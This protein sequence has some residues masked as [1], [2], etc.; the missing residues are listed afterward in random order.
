ML[1]DS[2]ILP[3][4]EQYSINQNGNQLC[5]Y[6]GLDYSLRPQLQTPFSNPQ[7]NPQQ[8]AYNTVMSKARVGV[9]W[10]FGDIANFFKFLDFKKSF[11]LGLSPI[12]KMY[13][14]CGFLMNIHTC[15]CSSMTSSYFNIDPPTVH[16][17]LA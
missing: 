13:I 9:E 5:I 8:A 3:L 1:A 6:E 10:V 16:E 17:Y 15:M 7:L 12:G 4:L 2:A 11:T 14:V